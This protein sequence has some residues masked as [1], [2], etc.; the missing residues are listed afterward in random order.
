MIDIEALNNPLMAQEPPTESSQSR[1]RVIP[2][3][4]SDSSEDEEIKEF[5]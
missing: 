5:V 4:N 2:L 1:R 3:H